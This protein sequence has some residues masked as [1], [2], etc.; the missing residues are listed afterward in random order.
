MISHNFNVSISD[1]CQIPMYLFGPH[2]K[3]KAL[4]SNS[5]GHRKWLDPWICSMV[6]MGFRSLYLLV[7][8]ARNGWD[9]GLL[10]LS[11]LITM[12]HS[13][14][15]DLFRTSKF[16]SDIL[17]KTGYSHLYHLLSACFKDG[18]SAV[19]C[20]LCK[21]GP[22]ARWLGT[23]KSM[24]FVREHPIEM[25]DDWGYPYDSGNLHMTSYDLFYGHVFVARKDM[26]R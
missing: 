13:L 23:P 24:V 17:K 18:R 22:M 21:D 19:I 26:E 8:N 5:A 3:P 4:R 7:L 10:G 25:D 2:S 1:F 6:S 20:R 9:W 11:L 15:P 16:T 12:D 14:I